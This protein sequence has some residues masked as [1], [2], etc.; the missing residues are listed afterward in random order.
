MDERGRN[1]AGD[2]V[3]GYRLVRR[4]AH[5]T[6]SEVYLGR[7]PGPSGGSLTPTRPVT[8]VLKIFRP[9]ADEH[10]ID[11][12]V[13]AMLAVPPMTLV[14]LTDVAT[15][16]DGRPCLVLDRLAGPSLATLLQDRGGIG[17]GEVVT[18]LATVCTALHALHTAGFS[19]PQVHP[20]AVRFDGT[21][22]PVVLGLGG[23]QEIPPGPAGVARKR[24]DL[25]RLAGFARAVI[26]HLDDRA[27]PAEGAAAVLAEFKAAA[28]RRPLPADLTGPEAALF[29]WAPATAVDGISAGAIDAGVIDAGGV[30]AGGVDATSVGRVTARPMAEAGTP[31]RAVALARPGGTEARGTMRRRLERLVHGWRLNLRDRVRAAL[32][33]VPGRR[34]VSAVLRRIPRKP[35]LAGLGVA[36]VVLVAA[37]T[38][39]EPARSP[40]APDSG[41]VQGT[42]QSAEPERG[43]PG[44]ER[45][46]GAVAATG[47]PTAS[48]TVGGEGAEAE[49]TD[50]PA[51]AV[52]DLLRRRE[53]CLTEASVLCLDG[54]DQA[55]SVA[56]EADSYAVRQRQEAGD[57]G[58]ST[59][60]GRA[61]QLTATVQERSGNAALVVLSGIG[62]EGANTQ[63]ASALVIRGEAG[64]RL[65][66]LFDY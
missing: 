26:D 53:Q 51:A 40:A 37:L 59:E 4:L 27:G 55:G 14:R 28:T 11:R 5:G 36:G 65:R 35:A 20:A 7:S 18:I 39:L 63:P 12:Q 52:L 29:T 41:P 3:A 49:T 60:R 56:L 25:V 13:R 54:V 44:A 23:L 61:E 22:R 6:Q 46:D 31:A 33:L 66:E 8:A 58:S 21:G 45:T 2:V 1:D 9:G 32:A 64:W 19:H 38:L 17:P 50:D 16:P 42:H 57:T 43:Q 47:T 48:A 15:A 10:A 24:D 34:P 30:G 62:E